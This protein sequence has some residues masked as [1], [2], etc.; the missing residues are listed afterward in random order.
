ME[1]VITIALLIVPIISLVALG[2]SIRV[3]AKQQALKGLVM[4][5]SKMINATATNDP[6]ERALSAYRINES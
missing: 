5:F 3:S 4:D 6:V 1:V 2:L